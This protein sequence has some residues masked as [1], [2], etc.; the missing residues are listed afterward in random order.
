MDIASSP[1]PSV[2]KAPTPAPARP[3]SG[4]GATSAFEAMKRVAQT[5]PAAKERKPQPR[6]PAE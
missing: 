3:H 1:S 6:S 5:K 4:E 2:P